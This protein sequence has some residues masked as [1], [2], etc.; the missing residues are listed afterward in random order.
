LTNEYQ[1]GL[2]S[3]KKNANGT[4][5]EEWFLVLLSRALLVPIDAVS[6]TMIMLSN[7]LQ[8]I[9]EQVFFLA[10]REDF[11]N[12]ALEGFV[13]PTS[14]QG[15]S[16]RGLIVTFMVSREHRDEVENMLLLLGHRLVLRVSKMH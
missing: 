8:N 16:D 4:I 5:D 2:K 12:V 1:I 10:S 9:F 7:L 15:V 14:D 11:F 3:W 13:V 6:N